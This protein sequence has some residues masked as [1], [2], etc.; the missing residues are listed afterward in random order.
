M[1]RVVMALERCVHIAVLAS[2][3][4]TVPSGD[5]EITRAESG[6][7]ATQLIH[8]L[9]PSSVCI[10]VVVFAF[11][12]LTMPSADPDATRAESGEKATEFTE[13]L[14]PSSVYV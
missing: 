13:Y 2:Q 7:K 3:I 9:W 14:W 6:E 4:L 11:Q 8:S 1:Y 12:I 5:A 10:H